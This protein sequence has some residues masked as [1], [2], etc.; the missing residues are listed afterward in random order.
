LAEPPPLAISEPASNTLLCTGGGLVR[1]C[2]EEGGVV[3]EVTGDGPV[4]S[5]TARSMP[6]AHAPSGRGLAIVGK[7]RDDVA[8]RT[9]GT[10]TV[11]RLWVKSGQADPA[12]GGRTRR[13]RTQVS[14]KALGWLTASDNR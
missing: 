5:R 4:A 2:A 6:P 14:S 11:V 1:M 3:C 8:I 12:P 9:E 13:A 10:R 7:V